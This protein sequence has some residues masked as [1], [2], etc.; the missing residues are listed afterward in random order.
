MRRS[1]TMSVVRSTALCGVAVCAL[2]FGVVPAAHAAEAADSVTVRSAAASGRGVAAT[3][4]YSCTADG[5]V[6]ALRVSASDTV[7]GGVFQGTADAV[8]DGRS[9]RTVLIADRVA[10][11]AARSGD[12][13]VLSASLGMRF[14]IDFSAT[15]TTGGPRV[16]D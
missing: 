7:T 4:V 13:C 8:C 6:D 11:P 10:G 14:D 15:A 3:V 12:N 9:H 1:K 16:L 5:F 2:Q